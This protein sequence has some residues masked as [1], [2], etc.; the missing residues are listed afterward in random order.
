M[1]KSLKFEII[2]GAAA[3]LVALA[4]AMVFIFIISDVPF[5][6]LYNLIVAPFTRMRYIWIILERMIPIIFT[7]LATC[8]MFNAN[9]CNLAGE[10]AV[11]GGLVASACAIYACR[12]CCMPPP[13]SRP[14]CSSAG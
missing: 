4:V 5:Q 3:I 1:R 8:V 9:Q 2:R 12:P 14:R 11:F 10:G 13:A 6:A 7:G